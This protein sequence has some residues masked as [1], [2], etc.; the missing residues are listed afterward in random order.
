MEEEQ[1]PPW[2]PDGQEEAPSGIE[3]EADSS[4]APMPDAPG[5]V[6][7]DVPGDARW[8]S[9]TTQ[10]V[11]Q[12]VV[13][14]SRSQSLNAL[15]VR[16]YLSAWSAYMLA[17][18]TRGW[19]RL[20][21]AGRPKLT[22]ILTLAA[23]VA[24]LSCGALMVLATPGHAKQPLALGSAPLNGTAS[25]SVSP[26]AGPTFTPAILAI[27]HRPPSPQGCVQ[28]IAPSP[29]QGPFGP[30]YT[31][32][33]YAG[34]G[35]EVALTFDDG[36]NPNFTPQIL[37]EL[38]TAGV[39]ATFF[40]VGRHA[41]THPELVRQ[42]WE[43]GNAIG[44]HTFDHEWIPGLSQQRLQE[45]LDKTAQVIRD[46][47]GDQCL[48]LFRPPYGDIAPSAAAGTPAPDAPPPMPVPPIPATSTRAWQVIHGSGYTPINWDASG[49]DWLFPGVDTIVRQIS[50]ELRPGAIVLMHDGAPDTERQDRRQTV[51][52]L[53]AVLDAIRAHGLKPVTL[54]Q[55]LYDAG[56]VKRPLPPPPTPR[57]GHGANDGDPSGI[58]QGGFMLI[59]PG[60]ATLARRRLWRR[61]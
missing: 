34:V 26:T 42:E 50:S 5:D 35:N 23:L 32:H 47:T 30:I 55:L 14:A 53:P 20:S 18:L 59:A 39:H 61:R 33:G 6:P 4:A 48:W 3:H 37:D 13:P 46:A 41:Q 38:K 54:P 57:V 19:S 31:T 10:E 52:A 29:G 22:L 15:D 17:V 12:A 58:P 45:T 21:T 1:R 25:P 27:P 51:A 16:S 36:P 28:G 40:V 8:E 44:N 2:E 7:G 11:P 49:H 56:I 24:I 60:M 43:A 9:A